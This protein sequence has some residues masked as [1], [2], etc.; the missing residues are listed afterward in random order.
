[1]SLDVYLT[2]KEHAEPNDE[3]GIFVRIGGRTRQI[4]REAWDKLYP[5]NC[6]FGIRDFRV[7]SDNFFLDV[8]AQGLLLGITMKW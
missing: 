4:S 1:M 3:S 8:R 5:I 7:L 2:M 6:G